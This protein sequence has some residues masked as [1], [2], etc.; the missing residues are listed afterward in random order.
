MTSS[1]RI[2]FGARV[3]VWLV[4]WLARRIGLPPAR[5]STLV[6]QRNIPIQTADGVTL[7]A[8]SWHPLGDD[9]AHLI[10]IRTPY[11]RGGLQGATLAILL[12]QYGFRVFTQSCRGTDGSGGEFVP[13][14]FEK[15]DA[16]DTLQWL[17]GQAW[18]Q[19]KFATYGA[20]YVGYTQWALASNLPQELV[21]MNPQIAPINPVTLLYGKGIFAYEIAMMWTSLMPNPPSRLLLLLGAKGRAK[22]ILAAA[23]SLPLEQSY[24]AANQGR[25]SSFLESWLE[26]GDPADP[27]WAT[28]DHSGVLDKINV[29]ILL[30]GGWFDM[31]TGEIFAQ[32]AKLRAR[33]V[34][35]AVMMADASHS[36]FVK[37]VAKTLPA[38]VAWFEAAFAGARPAQVGTVAGETVGTGQWQQF[39]QWPVSTQAL[40]LNLHAGGE[41]A[42]I[43]PQASAPDRYHYDPRDPTPSIGGE[44]LSLRVD[45]DNRPLMAR[46]DVLSYMTAP[47][48]QPIEIVGVARVDLWCESSLEHAD[49][50]ARICDVAPDG[51][52]R[53][54]CES[55]RRVRPGQVTVEPDGVW[56]LQIHMAESLCR[57]AAGHRI[58][59]IVS[60]GAHPR[61]MRNAG[62]AE[63]LATATT[64]LGADQKIFHDPAHPSCVVLQ[65]RAVGR[66]DA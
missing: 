4:Q 56:S 61:F 51:H 10:V 16:A 46:Q 6:R 57:F 36:G 41:L 37:S 7:L 21:A 18:F 15:S 1:T 20:S 5:H 58:C 12:A 11:G 53:M 22:A 35:A 64:L 25:R 59:L 31:F 45:Q 44:L 27:W 60:S 55:I 9:S 40:T 43:A 38:T 28:F 63:P 52:A 39:S 34:D 50:F 42:E 49:F 48:P 23:T 13:F 32:Y 54:V 3:L 26:H 47:L 33:N 24:I 14:A 62:T 66:A 30:Q 17:R 2:D 19:G 29:P 8:E 65:M